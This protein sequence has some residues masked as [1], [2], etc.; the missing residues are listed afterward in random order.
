MEIVRAKFVW[1]MIVRWD[2]PHRHV[3]IVRVGIWTSRVPHGSWT[4]DVFPRSIM[5]IRLREYL[6]FWGISFHG[7]I[8]HCI[9]WHPSFLMIMCF[10]G[11]WKVLDIWLPLF[12]ELDLVCC[13]YLWVPFC[14]SC[15]W[16]ILSLLLRIC[17][18]LKWLLLSWVLCKLW[19]VRL[20]WFYAGCSCGGSVG[21]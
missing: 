6:V 2:R 21:V 13:W 8:L 5:Y 14:G 19:T 17:N 4:L 7:V 1:F 18:L 9:P 16:W 15:D 20:G 3:E 10:I 12:D 11:G